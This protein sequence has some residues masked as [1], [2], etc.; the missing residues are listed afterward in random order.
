MRGAMNTLSPRTVKATKRVDFESKSPSY[1]LS[2][3]RAPGIWYRLEIS[4]ICLVPDIGSFLPWLDT[5][6]C[7]EILILAGAW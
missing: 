6:F 7:V 5:H 4:F 1:V 3:I 2:T